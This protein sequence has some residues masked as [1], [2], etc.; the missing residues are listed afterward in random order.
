MSE[1]I[2]SNAIYLDEVPH[3]QWKNYFGN[4][5]RSVAYLTD[6]EKKGQI[7]FFGFDTVGNRKT[8]IIPWKSW[9]KYR[10]KYETPEKDIYENFVETKWYNSS[11]ERKKRLDDIGSSLH[12]VECLRPEQEFLQEAFY[13]VALD[14]D[15]NKQDLRVQFI[16]IETEISEVFEKP[17][18]AR[19]RINMITIYDSETQKY[20]TWSL[21]HAKIDFKEEPLCN[22]PKS[23]FVFYEFHDNEERLLEHFLDWVE[24]NYPDVSMGWNIK[25]YDWPYIVRRIENVLGKGAAARLSPVGKYRIK[26][27][28][29]DNERAD[30]GAEIEVDIAGL[31]IADGLVLYRDKFHLAGGPLDGGHGL[32]NVGEHEGLG[33]KIQ[34]K[35]TLKDLYL[36]DYQKFYEYNVRDV[37]LVVKIEEKCKMIAL[38]RMVA[39]AG[40]CN[41]DTIYSSISYLIGSVTQFARL[42]MDRI[43]QSYL[44]VKKERESYEGAYVFE[45]IPGVYDGGIACVDFNSLYPS[46]IRVMNL[47][48]ETYVGKLSRIMDIDKLGGA[49][50][51]AFNS[52][53][54]IDLNDPTLDELWFYPQGDIKK[55]KK[56]K[57]EAIMKLLET[58]CIFTRNNTLFLKHSVKQG[59]VSGWCKHFYNLR[60]TT[61]KKMQALDLALYN[62]EI[63]KDKIAETKVEI[64][65]LDAKQMA[66]KLAINSIYGILGTNHSPLYIVELAQTITR[67]GKFCNISASKFIAK[68]FK[69]RFGADENYITAVSGDTDSQFVNISCLVQNLLKQGI[70]AGRDISKWSDD[71]KLKLWKFVDGFVENEVNPYVQNLVKDYCHTEHPEVLRY[72]LEYVSACGI[73]EAK[74]HYATRKVIAEG[75]ELIDKIKYSG[76][77]IKKGSVP[78]Q[79]KD[80][81]KD[82][83]EGILLHSWKETDFIEY[84]YKA[85]DG[86]KS[87]SIDEISFWKGY[88]SAREAAGFLQMQKGS[89]AVASAS[90]YYNQIIKKLGLGKKYDQILLG[91]KVRFC[92]VKP[93][94]EY[95]IS[96]IA[97]PDDQWPEEFNKIFEID[98]EVMFDKLVTSSLKGLMTATKFSK[99]DPS[100]QVEFDVSEL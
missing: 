51:V 2:F 68:T 89:T 29:H 20:Y 98:Y 73:Y 7:V 80:V 63:P 27:I 71:D 1:S 64:Q 65:N 86:F 4:G 15:F 31:F 40:L 24:A 37:D 88:A 6:H 53:G 30:V 66:Y 70:G 28:N 99:V 60:K 67:L 39:G 100:K 84:I 19:N 75:P 14:P 11:F 8:Y 3:D 62:G 52:E 87:M 69:E 48:P 83:Y 26:E 35:G 91:Q 74:K 41:Y 54:P 81:L 13:K 92:Y 44:N 76:I 95:R 34:Y 56:V 96:Y 10:V 82:V 45:P 21:E 58:K 77:E 90:T 33:K 36:K 16:D 32:S 57:K 46:S 79:V 85:W 78:Q 59:V 61:K 42:F 50:R 18:D 12:I 17:A 25:G 38:S 94:N 23:K 5:Y 22:Y 43:F 97:F 93:T 47:S 9:I 49:W 55:R 72:S